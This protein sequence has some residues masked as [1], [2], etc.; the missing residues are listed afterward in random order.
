[1]QKFRRNKKNS[2][3]KILTQKRDGRIYFPAHVERNIDIL[4]LLLTQGTHFFTSPLPKQGNLLTLL[5]YPP[6]LTGHHNTFFTTTIEICQWDNTQNFNNEEDDLGTFSTSQKLPTF[7]EQMQTNYKMQF[8][9]LTIFIILQNIVGCP[10]WRSQKALAL[11]TNIKNH[12]NYLDIWK[13]D[14]TKTK[15][16]KSLK[17]DTNTQT[18]RN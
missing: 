12:K 3:A 17:I 16:S 6:N 8:N 1:M 5:L 9:S 10:E 2:Q 14:L 15:T 4:L 11:K 7:S 13:F 18:S